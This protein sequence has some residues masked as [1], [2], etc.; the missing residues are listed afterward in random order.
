M[1]ENLRDFVQNLEAMAT[2]ALATLGPWLA[3]ISSAALV[4]RASVAHLGWSDLLGLVAGA[5]IE[6]LGLTATSTALTLWGYNEGR[7]KSDP[8]APFPLAVALV[9]F[10]YVST[11]GL[12]V[13]LDV[14]PDL[15]RFAPAIFPTL[16]LV[17]TVNLALRAQH[18]R[19]LATIESVKAE[20][21]AQRQ[22][23]RREARQRASGDA[24]NNGRMDALQTARLTKKAQ[25]LDALLDVYRDNP[26]IGPTDAGRLI[27]VSRQTVYTYQSELEQAGRL[28]RNGQGVEVLT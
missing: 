5:I 11:L 20:R 7:R 13:V 22:S 3:P 28:R 12:T 8:V 16:A 15:A 1:L 23:K 2:D 18:K 21:K 17:G 9:G 25:R 27:G 26:D 4:A 19:R 10:Y 6:I 14:L 24:S